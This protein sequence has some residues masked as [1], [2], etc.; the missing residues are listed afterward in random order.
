MSS[1]EILTQRKNKF[2]K[3]GRNKGFATGEEGLSSLKIK[4]N[5]LE[6]FLD[7]KRYIYSLIGILII[8][9]VLLTLLL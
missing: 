2:L 5:Y 4:Q 9:A 7:D 3:I 6:K 8:S 1:E